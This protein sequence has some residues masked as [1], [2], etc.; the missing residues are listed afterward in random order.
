MRSEGYVGIYILCSGLNSGRFVG[1]GQS[2]EVW[3]AIFPYYMDLWLAQ[4][5]LSAVTRIVP[6]TDLQKVETAISQDAV[7][8]FDDEQLQTFPNIT[9]LQSELHRMQRQIDRAVNNAALNPGRALD[10]AIRSTRGRFVFGLP[11]IFAKHIQGALKG[12]RFVYLIDEFENLADDQQ[13][14]V[15]S[16]VREKQ[17][18]VN[19]I[20]GSRTYGIRTRRTYS[21]GEENK[22]GS[23]FTELRLNR[24]YTQN[25]NAYGTFCRNVVARR[26]SEYGYPISLES[27]R[28]SIDALFEAAPNLNTLV[29]PNPLE[30]RHMIRLRQNLTELLQTTSPLGLTSGQ[31]IDDIIRLIKNEHDVLIERANILLLY[32]AW[33]SRRNLKDYAKELNLHP[34]GH[35]AHNS[36]QDRILSHFA[37][38]LTAQTL[39]DLDLRRQSYLGFDTFVDM[40]DG[41]PRNLLV[42]LKNIFGWAKFLGEDPG[43]T[44]VSMTAQW[45]GVLEA[46]E[47]FWQDAKPAHDIGDHVQESIARLGDLFRA[48]RFS[49][50]PVESSLASFSVDLS[51]CTPETRETIE[52]A[53]QWSMLNEVVRGQRD[54]NSGRVLSKFH[55]SKMLSPRWDLPIGRRGA[56]TLSTIEANAIFDRQHAAAFEAVLDER[57]SRFNAPFRRERDGAVAQPTLGGLL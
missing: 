2:V 56:I 9:D 23:E 21:A 11:Q 44:P 46:S 10:V 4:L 1:K 8:L 51:S 14:Y 13:Q 48:H 30:R 22:K 50:K 37:I 18:P 49:D 54:R 26:L 25:K 34:G 52:L 24:R 45:H 15:N 6:P 53:T 57:V 31:D 28:D 42:L 36:P 19:F 35:A 3:Q 43:I 5:L 39:R 33:F 20:I 29:N 40:S 47:W 41:L 7:M 12:L 32:Q 17:P 16:L 55:L 27:P 38:D